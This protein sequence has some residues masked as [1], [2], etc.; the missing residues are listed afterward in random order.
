MVHM[1]T[2]QMPPQQTCAHLRSASVHRL[3]ANVVQH[4]RGGG[5]GTRRTHSP[6]CSSGLGGYCRGS[7]PRARRAAGAGPKP[8]ITC[9]RTPI[10]LPARNRQMQYQG[11]HELQTL[12]MCSGQLLPQDRHL[13]LSHVEQSLAIC[14]GKGLPHTMHLSVLQLLHN[15]A[16]RS[17][18]DRPHEMHF[19]IDVSS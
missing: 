8:N 4:L 10:V 1:W 9:A 14:W 6:P 17:A 12:A 5:C 2:S 16:I 7:P 15:L 13:P 11:A 19:A 18:N 3:Y